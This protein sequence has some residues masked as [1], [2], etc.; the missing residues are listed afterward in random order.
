MHRRWI[1]PYN[2]ASSTRLIAASRRLNSQ[3][4]NLTQVQRVHEFKVSRDG[5]RG[6]G[7]DRD[8]NQSGCKPS[9]VYTRRADRGWIQIDVVGRARRESHRSASKGL[10]PAAAEGGSRGNVD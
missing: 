5:G 10:N 1:P 8:G 3:P 7:H 2:T 4:E 9:C 6:S